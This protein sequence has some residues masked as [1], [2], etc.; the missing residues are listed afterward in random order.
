VPNSQDLSKITSEA[1][2]DDA[3]ALIITPEQYRAAHGIE[4]TR[5]YLKLNDHLTKKEA[6]EH[7]VWRALAE[8]DG[9]LLKEYVD[10]LFGLCA[11]RWSQYHCMKVLIDKKPAQHTLRQCALDE[12]HRYG[13]L[14]CAGRS[15][16]VFDPVSLRDQHSRI[17]GFMFPWS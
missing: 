12:P 11:G 4:L 15:D 7:P 14:V 8:D 16:T 3:G 2:L 6:N 10:A 17:V 1:K 13:R 5:K 9:A